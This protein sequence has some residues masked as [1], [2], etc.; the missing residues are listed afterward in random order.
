[1]N[2][3][4]YWNQ[5]CRTQWGVNG[6]WFR[7]EDGFRVGTAVPS[8]GSPAARG[9]GFGPGFAGN[10]YSFAVG[11]KHYFTPNLYGRAALRVDWYD[12]EKANGKSPFNNGTK[13]SQELVVFDVVATF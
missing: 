1:V 2:S 7:D 12:G 4:L 10:F 6:E 9:W 8:A 3:Y 5:T 13:D 11:P